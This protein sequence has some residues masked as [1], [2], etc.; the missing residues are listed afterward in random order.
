VTDGKQRRILI[1]RINCYASYQKVDK[2]GR[3]NIP[4]ELIEYAHLDKE[5][6]VLGFVKRFEIWDP[7]K[8]DID[9][10]KN[11]PQYQELSGFFDF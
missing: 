3:I 5:V 4:A 2:Q 9:T 7:T 11:E 8:L 1:R 6:I 10:Q